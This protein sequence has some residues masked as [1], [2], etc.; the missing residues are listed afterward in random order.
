M[1][2]QLD[3]TNEGLI[4][5]GALMDALVSRSITGVD[6]GRVEQLLAYADSRSSGYVVISNFIEKLQ[7]LGAE[8]EEEQRMRQFGRTVGSQ[9][10]NLRQELNR[11]D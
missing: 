4:N 3:N 5:T 8:T 9:G 10:L 11:F 7:T 2:S 1:L 6:P